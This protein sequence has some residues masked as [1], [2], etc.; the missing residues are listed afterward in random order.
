[1]TTQSIPREGARVQAFKKALHTL[2]LGRRLK[3]YGI[4]RR[5]EPT[6]RI[7]VFVLCALWLNAPSV[8]QMSAYV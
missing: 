8:A 4:V 3:R 5:G 2:T 6:Y 1:M 7:V